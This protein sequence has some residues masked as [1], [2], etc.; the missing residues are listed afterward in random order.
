MKRFIATAS[1]LGATALA[2]T[3]C[4]STGSSDAGMS[5][6]AMS[7]MAPSSMSASSMGSMQEG[8]F[9]G[10]N[11]KM[12]KGTA[13]VENGIVT[14]TGFSSDE[15]PDL[16]LY[17]ADGTSEQEVTSGTELGKVSFDTASQTFKLP[18]GAM[19]KDVVVHCDKA[20]AV[21]GAA[22]LGS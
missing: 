15:G 11:G 8:T 6:Q 12:V 14:L 5:S 16:H 3:A 9:T 7:S 17:L 21:F 1:L 10:L 22:M 2:L 4:S 13:T 18:E 19:G 20:K